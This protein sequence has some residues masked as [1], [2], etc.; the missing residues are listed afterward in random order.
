MATINVKQRHLTVA[1]RGSVTVLQFMENQIVMMRAVNRLGTAYNYEKT[2]KNIEEFLGGIDIPFTSIDEQFIYEYNVF[3]IKRGLVRNSVSFYMRILRAVYNKA[4][5]LKLVKKPSD[6]FVDVYTGVD[7]TRKRAVS[8]SVISQLYKLDLP[9]GSQ[10][11]MTRD[12][13][14]FSYCT[15]GMAF[16]DIAHLKKD[17]IRNGVICYAR[18]KTGQQL[19]VKVESAIKKIIERYSC[20]A[21]DYVFPILTTSEPKQAYEEYR[22]AINNYNRLLRKLAEMLPSGCKLTSYTS[23][24]SWATAA[25]N[26]NVPISVISAGMGHSLEQTTQIYIKSIEDNEIDDANARIIEMLG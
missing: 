12:I 2:K 13:F 21:S 1:G 18:R 9:E 24:H 25:R 22:L 6:L 16:V 7:K 10:L 20:S 5:R 15:R 14:I 3:L 26:H 23:R 4:V 8:E 11:A 19:S 17:N